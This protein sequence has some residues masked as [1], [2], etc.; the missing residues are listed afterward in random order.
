M[1]S[2]LTGAAVRPNT[3]MFLDHKYGRELHAVSSSLILNFARFSLPKSLT[4]I[5]VNTYYTQ[6]ESSYNRNKKMKVKI[7]RKVSPVLYEQQIV[8]WRVCDELPLVW[9]K[10][11]ERN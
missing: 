11:D 3:S 2:S 10:E 4:T 9:G 6:L 1:S 5:I 8:P 7:E